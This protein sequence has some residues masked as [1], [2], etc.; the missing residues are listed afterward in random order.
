MT[1][2]EEMLKYV[3]EHNEF[4]KN[5][6]KE[7][8]IKDP[9]D[10]TQ[11]P[12]LTR[13]ELQ[14]NRYNMFSDGYKN[15]YY[16]QQLVRKTSSG[17][18]G[19]PINVYWDLPDYYSTMK[20]LWHRRKKHYGILP[21]DKQLVF[22]FIKNENFDKKKEIYY[23]NEPANIL[24]ID[25]DAILNDSLHKKLIKLINDFRPSWIYIRPFVLQKF[26][27]IFSNNFDYIPSLK[28]IETYGELLSST[29]RKHAN[30]FFNV[31]VINMY[32]S[33]EVNS[34]A[35]ECPC[36][37]KHILENNVFVEC[38]GNKAYFE[39]GEG[40]LIVTTLTNKA[41]PLIRY[42]Q[43]DV[44]KIQKNS[45]V[46]GCDS[47]EAVIEQIYGRNI[48]ILKLENG[49]E[50]NP[51]VFLDIMATV[52]N[53]YD[54]MVLYYKFVFSVRKG[55]LWCYIDLNKDYMSWYQSIKS[56]IK[57]AFEKKFNLIND[58][59]LEIILVPYIEVVDK[60]FKIFEIID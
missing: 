41:M 49:I 9:L 33:E 1:K 28:Y 20:T 38:Y 2:L 23:I 19:V 3:S 43:G 14:E 54:S 47:H 37:K 10:I 55:T 13:K 7:Y 53:L 39:C 51:L 40:E 59:A 5:R 45:C 25:I 50:L 8:G 15:K 24:N 34:I 32:G 60:K 18:S 17:S 44:V 11:W 26:L 35:Y 22:S 31:P 42:N 56:S 48:E 58:F 57:N 21:S 29:L 52:I 12:I 16:W 27:D 36:Q 46:C 6:I 30:T 4:Y